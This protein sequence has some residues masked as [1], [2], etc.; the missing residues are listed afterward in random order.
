MIRR[1]LLATTVSSFS[2]PLWANGLEDEIWDV[3]IV[4]SGVAGLSAACSALQAGSKRILILEKAQLS[5]V[6]PF[7]LPGTLRELTENDRKNLVLL[8]RRN[9]CSG[10]CWISAVMKMTLNSPRL[11]AINLKRPF[12]GLKIWELSGRKE[13][14]KQLPGFIPEAI[15]QVQC[16]PVT[17]M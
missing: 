4:G 8:T 2:F 17:I 3:I 6:T 7:Y 15:S 12:I 5:E 9:L 16:A 14:F 11:S 10:T 13:F 1:E